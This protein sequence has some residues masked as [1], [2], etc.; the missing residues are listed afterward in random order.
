MNSPDHQGPKVLFAASM[1]SMVLGSIHAFSV[2]LEPLETTFKSS[3]GTVSLIYSFSLVFLTISVLFGPAVYSRLQPATIYIWVAFLGAIGT[4]LAGIATG[5]ETV[6]IG[7][8]FIF[9]IANGLGYGFGLQ[10]AARAN[11]DHAGFAM[12]VVTAA[13]ALGAVL[14]PYGFEVALAY[15][16]FFLAMIAL[17]S[18]IFFVALGAALIVLRSGAQYSDA[19]AKPK[20]FNLP[21]G[22]IAAIWVAYGSGVAAG[23]MAIGHAA[24]IAATAGFAGWVATAVIAGCNLVGSLLSGWLSEKVSHR[25]ILTVLPLLGTAALLALSVF[26][27]LTIAL[28]G[29]VGF[30]YGGTIATYPAAISVLF[31]GEDGP[32]AYGRIFTA[33]GLAGLLAPWLAGQIY[34]WDGSYVLALWVAA[35]LGIISAISAQKSMRHS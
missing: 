2:F 4:G 6:W 28:L 23:L 22:R 33:W 35:G 3:R 31:P 13:Y 1:V 30:A 15:G 16:G 26:P 24:G 8:S 17:G 7:Y 9:G 34:D 29:V 12:G 20:T 27:G 18:V 19:Q 25:R 32:I 21:L 11:P 5:L 14:A 10:F